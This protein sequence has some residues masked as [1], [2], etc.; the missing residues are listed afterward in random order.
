[1]TG[2]VVT[3]AEEAVGVNTG[4]WVPVGLAVGLTASPS[5]GLTVG[6]GAVVESAVDG[7]TV[8]IRVSVP[9]GCPQETSSKPT[10][11]TMAE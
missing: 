10:T 1:M 11:A 7:T 8:G 9:S 2:E 5:P 3:T 4:A 6:V